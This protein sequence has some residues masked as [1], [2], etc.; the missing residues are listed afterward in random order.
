MLLTASCPGTCS[1]NFGCSSSHCC[2]TNS[3]NGTV[4]S[5]QDL[6]HIPANV[7][8]SACSRETAVCNQHYSYTISITHTQGHLNRYCGVST[9]I[10]NSTRKAW[11]TPRNAEWCKPGT[12]VEVRCCE[13]ETHGELPH[14]HGP[15][16]D[17]AP[18]IQCAS[19]HQT[20]CR[21]EYPYCSY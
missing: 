6:P 21:I 11:I 1:I 4:K 9:H 5:C 18:Q 15:C 20:T 7:S 10:T 13:Y 12:S 19:T 3:P 17:S 8:R 2:H 14:R 16:R